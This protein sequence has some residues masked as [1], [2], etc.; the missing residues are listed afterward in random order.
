MS[1]RAFILGGTGQI[2]RTVALDL[3]AAGWGVTVSHRG[4][5]PP[6]EELI[7]HGAR[8]AVLQ[9]DNPGDL[10]L[11]LGPG[12][13]ALIDTIAF[14]LGHACQLVAVQGSVGSFV[15]ISSASVYRDA[16]GRT[17][18]EAPQNG[19]PTLPN[20]IPETHPTVDPGPNT[21]STRKIALERHLLDESAAPVTILRPCA[22]SGL[23][24]RHPREWWFVKRI[25]DRRPVIPLAYRGLSRFHTSFVANIAA[26]IRVAVG[27]PGRRV[28]N[29]A[30][31]FAPTVADIAARIAR[32]LDYDGRIV[33]VDEQ[34]YPPAVGRTPWS[35]PRPFVLDCRAALDLGYSPAATY[36]DAI[37]PICDWLVATVGE[38]EWK[39]RFPLLARYP[40]DLFDYAAEDKYF[41]E[42]RGI[43]QIV[44]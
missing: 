44:R 15:V 7:K 11:A 31:P 21:Y 4:T 40:R 39:E 20:P 24:S 13:D 9:R 25:L 33:A 37:K 28:L 19:F 16:L 17:L 30:D 23:G 3:L 34:G 35:V 22:I 6:P 12:T 10:A 2:G 8:I 18:D 32:H 36:A 26:L 14:D 1:R 29:I 27:A 41:R 5:H 43:E 42:S 38:G